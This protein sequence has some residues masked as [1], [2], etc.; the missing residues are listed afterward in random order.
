ML[1]VAITCIVVVLA[2]ARP[3]RAGL[4]PDLEIAIHLKILSFDAGLKDR[5]KGDALVI[6]VLHPPDRKADATDFVAAITSADRHKVTVH[7]K[8]LRAV[9]VPITAELGAQ[10]AGINAVYVTASATGEQA[11]LVARVAQ[12]GKLPS[13]CGSRAFLAANGLAVAVVAKANKPSI[14]VHAG[15]AGRAG[16]ILDS[17]LLRLAEVV[18]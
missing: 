12:T 2:M 8:R 7:G 13:L 15:N 18:K 11:A 9:A 10:L 3:A 14:V 6:A 5:V 4:P 17:K 16:M 1:R